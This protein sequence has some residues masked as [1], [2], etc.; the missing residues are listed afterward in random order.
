MI[1]IRRQQVSVPAHLVR[2]CL[3]RFANLARKFAITPPL[4]YAEGQEHAKDN[5]DRFR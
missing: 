1:A 5:Q 2:E 4:V 3:A